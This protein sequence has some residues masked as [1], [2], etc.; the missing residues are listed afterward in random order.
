[1]KRGLPLYAAAS[2]GAILLAG[3]LLSLIYQGAAERRAIAISAGVAFVVQCLAFAV[4]SL[5]AK[6]N[7]A[8]AGWGL[9]AIISLATLV[10]AGFAFRAAG[11]PTNAALLSLAVFLFITE[12]I[13][14][15]LLLRP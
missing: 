2:A 4:A 15:P 12:L 7:Q 8:I 9:G 14:P 5:L 6:A 11:L 10:V 1:M 3:G 13:E